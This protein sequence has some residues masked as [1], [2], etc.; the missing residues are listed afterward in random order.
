[1]SWISHS[2]QHNIIVRTRIATSHTTHCCNLARQIRATSSQTR[3]CLLPEQ[4]RTLEQ[5]KETPR[6]F[7]S[8]GAVFVPFSLFVAS[9]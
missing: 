3:F 7:Y 6:S 8:H 4:S 2:N 1:M 9:T 5:E